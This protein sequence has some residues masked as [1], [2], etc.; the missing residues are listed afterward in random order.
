VWN[1]LK[2]GQ[3]KQIAVFIADVSAPL[4]IRK[5][6]YVMELIYSEY[7]LNSVALTVMLM[8]IETLRIRQRIVVRNL[9]NS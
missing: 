1:R 6:S 7:L 5:H 2:A 4:L 9:L 3:M 8:N